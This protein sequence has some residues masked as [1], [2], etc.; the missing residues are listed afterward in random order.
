MSLE[1]LKTPVR[2][3][4]ARR[5]ASSSTG[6]RGVP[7]QRALTMKPV[8]K[9]SPVPWLPEH[10][11]VKSI[12]RRGRS[13]RSASDNDKRCLTKPATAT[14]HA[15]GVVK[16]SRYAVVRD[17]MELLGRDEPGVELLPDEL[18]SDELR[19]GKRR[20]LVEPREDHVAGLSQ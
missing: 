7:A 17:E 10:S 14:R 15:A 1:V 9:G 6:A 20:G 11:N 8:A 19:G 5:P 2:G 4:Q 12:S 16:T 3:P 18:A 13:L